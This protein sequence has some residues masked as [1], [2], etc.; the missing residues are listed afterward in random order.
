MTPRSL[1]YAANWK[2]HHGPAAT[3]A[4]MEVAERRVARLA[5]RLERADP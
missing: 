5:R 2:M 3:R 1:I 4:F